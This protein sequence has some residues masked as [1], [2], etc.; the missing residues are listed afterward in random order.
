MLY[1]MDF[2]VRPIVWCVSPRFRAQQKYVRQLNAYLD[3]LPT[4]REANYEAIHH[5]QGTSRLW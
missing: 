1:I 5:D 4:P 2:V 3:Q